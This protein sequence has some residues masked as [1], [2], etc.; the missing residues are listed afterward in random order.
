MC[1]YIYIYI[2]ILCVYRIAA[3]RPGARSAEIRRQTPANEFENL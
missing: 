2:Y 1:V 3:T